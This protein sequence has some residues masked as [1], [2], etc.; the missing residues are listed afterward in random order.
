MSDSYFIKRG[1][2][3]NGPFTLK[4]LQKALSDKKLK[5]NDELSTSNDGPWERLSV[6]HKDIRAGKHPLNADA[7][8]GTYSFVDEWMQDEQRYQ[9]NADAQV[10]TYSFV[11]EW[12][13]DEQ[14]YQSQL[15]DTNKT[16]ITNAL[17]KFS[18]EFLHV[19]GTVLAGIAAIALVIAGIGILIA[20]WPLLIP[21][22][23]LV[24]IYKGNIR[25]SVP[26]DI[27]GDG[28]NDVYIHS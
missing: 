1:E 9:I 6:L 22:A 26:V 28:D 17:S 4:K 10:D 2:N 7:Q 11:D 19:V 14:R 8:V 20:A 15:S 13:Q 24:G 25:A 5:A 18:K 23:I 16:K 27:D 3:I 12:M 21:I